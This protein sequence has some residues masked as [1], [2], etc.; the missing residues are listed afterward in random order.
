VTIGVAALVIVLSVFNGFGSLVTTM[1]INF[2]P[3]IRVTAPSLERY[4]D[5]ID[6][7]EESDQVQSYS[8][9][10]QG[11]IILINKNTVEI[12]NLKG[13]PIDNEE[14]TSRIEQRVKFGNFDISN[15][16]ENVS[17]IILSLPIAL[18]LSV[19]TGDTVFATSAS[20]I[21]NTITRLSIPH[22]KRFIVSGIYEI[23]NKEYALEYIFASLSSAQKLLDM[24]NKISGLEIILN[25]LDDSESFKEELLKNFPN[26][27]L[28]VNTWYD[29]HKDLYRVMLIERWAAYIL[30]SLIIAVAAFNILSSLTMSVLEKKKDIGIL[31]SMGT[32]PSSIKKIF[33]FEGIL[34][35]VLGTVL[36]MIIGLTICYI[37]INFNIYSLDASKYVIDTLPVQVKISD[38]IAVSTMSFLLTFFA[39]KYPANRALR[40]K[41]I[42]AIKWE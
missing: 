21:R 23:S 29:L 13:V 36:G 38:I 39:S 30:L 15:N 10:A 28:N 3:H 20:Q 42:D 12:L 1:L 25:D 18:R 24:R 19:R 14:S 35:G 37:Q 2:D 7:L 5:I 4:T 32:T 41:L 31:R 11:K 9:F 17:G 34:I 8:Q 16:E 6:F 27:D 40:T 33:M 26:Y 22:S